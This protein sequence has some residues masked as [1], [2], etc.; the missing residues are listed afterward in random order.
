MHNP[1]KSIG[2]KRSRINSKIIRCSTELEL[3]VPVHQS[4]RHACL[5]YQRYLDGSSIYLEC[6]RARGSTLEPTIREMKHG[7][8]PPK[9]ANNDDFCKPL[10]HRNKLGR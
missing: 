6:V 10:K 9:W 1:I 7:Y 3:Y 2:T 8:L 4:W 5:Q